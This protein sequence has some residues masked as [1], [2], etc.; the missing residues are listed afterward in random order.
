MLP[1]LLYLLLNNREQTENNTFIHRHNLY[2]VKA[3]NIIFILLIIFSYKLRAQESDHSKFYMHHAGLME[4]GDYRYS[5]FTNGEY[6]LSDKL[7][8]SVH[9]VWVFMA[10]TVSLK[11]NLKNTEKSTLSFI[12]GISSP[13][14][15]MRLFAMSGT[16][17]LISPEFQIPVML[18]VKNGIIATRKLGDK[19]MITGDI[20]VEF[21]LF[22][23]KLEPG[24]SID[25]PIISP[26]NTV[27]Y[28]NAGLDI[29]LAAEGVLTG[30]LDYFS[31]IQFFLFPFEDDTYREEYLETSKY[32]GELTTMFFIKTGASF[33]IG[34]GTRLCYGDYPFGTQWHL[35][36]QL[37]FVK[38]VW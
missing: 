7:T 21:A 13:T 14:P 31:R 2:I 29:G 32:F 22:H 24:S 6:G 18:S 3:K 36:P 15:A 20:A 10:P 9:P 27:Y 33:K 1:S 26:R 25:L 38:Y 5:L 11:W 34:A 16:G 17:G 12:H 19:H 23:S 37:D 8:L 4:K 28:K 35:L 30:K